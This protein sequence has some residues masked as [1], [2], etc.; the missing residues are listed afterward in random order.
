MWLPIIITNGQAGADG[1]DD[2]GSASSGDL[3]SARFDGGL[4][5]DAVGFDTTLVS[6]SEARR[7]A[8]LEP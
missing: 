7:A 3:A 2:S 5:V 8:G 6:V 4:G 1:L